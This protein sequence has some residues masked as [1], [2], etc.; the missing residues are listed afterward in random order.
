MAKEKLQ[1]ISSF[2][3]Y[4]H[5]K[6]LNKD[7]QLLNLKAKEASKKAYAPYSNFHVGAA[8]LLSNNEIVSGNNQENSAYPSGLCAERVAVFYAGSLHPDCE[9]KCISIYCDTDRPISPCG[10]C[11]QA[12]IEYEQKQKNKIKVI[13]CSKE[14]KV[15]T[16][17]SISAFLP[18]QFDSSFLKK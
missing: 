18:L 5:E 7:E 4:D 15:I 2:M 14:N 11:R 12:L 8:I 13:L 10:A 3:V 6:E 16:S 9:I 17:E 1:I